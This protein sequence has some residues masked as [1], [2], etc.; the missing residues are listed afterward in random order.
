MKNY[1]IVIGLLVFISFGCSGKESVKPSADALLATEAYNRIDVIKNTYLLKDTGTLRGLIDAKLAESILEDLRFEK[2]ELS[3]TPG[4]VRITSE[5]VIVSVSW[6][7]IWK[8]AKK[9]DINNR[10]TANLILYKENMKLV[11]IDG[12]NPFII[13]LTRE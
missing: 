9:K 2:A 8:I 3:F 10:G 4:M 1:F 11:K 6:Q 7:G 12:D 13:P 5:S